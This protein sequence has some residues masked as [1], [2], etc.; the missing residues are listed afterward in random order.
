MLHDLF[1]LIFP[2]SP[3]LLKPSV[4]VLFRRFVSVLL[5]SFLPLSESVTF[6][7]S[8]LADLYDDFEIKILRRKPVGV[9]SVSQAEV[10]R[11]KR[12]Y[13]W[14]NMLNVFGKGLSSGFLKIRRIVRRTNDP[15]FRHR[16]CRGGQLT[17]CGKLWQALSKPHRSPPPSGEPWRFRVS[18]TPSSS[19]LSIHDCR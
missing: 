1:L 9:S 19:F 10:G 4:Y 13:E 12:F 7:F 16:V 8:P 17:A 2:S 11:T 3:C 15:V 18:G 14:T 5:S 6:L